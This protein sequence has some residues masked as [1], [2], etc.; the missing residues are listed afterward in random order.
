MLFLVGATACGSADEK[1]VMNAHSS[2]TA[3]STA[4]RSEGGHTPRH[5]ELTEAAVDVKDGV[6][7]F[8]W[9][10]AADFDSFKPQPWTLYSWVML[11]RGD[12]LKSRRVLVAHRP[13]EIQATVTFYPDHRPEADLPA[14]VFVGNE[15]RVTATVKQLGGWDL[16]RVHWRTTTGLTADNTDGFDADALAETSYP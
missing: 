11:F 1:V 7:T 13:D 9:K 3:H 8:I 5:L 10:V 2:Q 16:N 14:P 6:V 12:N 15:V 4:F